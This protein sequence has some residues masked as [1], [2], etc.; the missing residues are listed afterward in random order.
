M[1]DLLLDA[2]KS[3]KEMAKI[4]AENIIVYREGL[5]A[6]QILTLQNT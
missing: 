6:S 2:Y 1:A 3:F 4:N 5:N